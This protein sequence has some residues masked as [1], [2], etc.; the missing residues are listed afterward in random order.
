M[1]RFVGL[2]IG[3]SAGLSISPGNLKYGPCLP[4]RNWGSRVSG[5]HK[6]PN[7]WIFFILLSGVFVEVFSFRVLVIGDHVFRDLGFVRALLAAIFGDLV[8]VEVLGAAFF[9]VFVIGFDIDGIFLLGI[10][11]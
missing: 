7:W 4:A 3:L 10:F 5:L 2:S 1:L 11:I 9:G 6:N 8:F